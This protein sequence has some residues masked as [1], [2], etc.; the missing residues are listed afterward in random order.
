MTA[1][2]DR[3]LAV[4]REVAANHRL[5]SETLALSRCH[6]RVILQD[7]VSSHAEDAAGPTIRHGVVMTP[8][9][10]ALAASIGV[11]SLS[12]AR[13]P[14]VA[15]FTTGNDLVEPGMSLAAGQAYDSN[16]E[17]LMGL[18]RAEGLEP[19]AW[20]RLPDDRRQIEIA[21]RD[22]GCA[23][24]LV[25]ICGSSRSSA[26]GFVA[27]VLEQFG[28]VHLCDVPDVFGAPVQFASLDQAHVLGLPDDPLVLAAA[29]LT[30]GRALVDGLQGRIEPRQV[31]RAR[32]ARPVASVQ[33]QRAF[34]PGRIE[35]QDDGLWV[36]P[37]ESGLADSN[38]LIVLR[39]NSPILPAAAIVDVISL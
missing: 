28:T 33:L 22:A 35:V 18:L 34:V 2:L 32:L 24:D 8:A 13:R 6:G 12:V 10:V 25:V 17:L 11:P 20:P 39:E 23:F 27:G 36:D 16:R 1:S 37:Q 7:V 5:E 31:L 15:V 21:L 19:T 9:R 14:T 26:G 3:A 30:L 38:G 29:W 4:V